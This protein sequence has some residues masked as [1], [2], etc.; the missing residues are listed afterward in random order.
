MDIISIFSFIIRQ[1][2]RSLS[3]VRLCVVIMLQSQNFEQKER[4]IGTS[5][6]VPREFLF[7]I[8]DCSCLDDLYNI[9]TTKVSNNQRIEK[10]AR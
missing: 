4:K 7:S 5:R 8:I 6:L 1:S 10:E 3:I 2:I 9:A